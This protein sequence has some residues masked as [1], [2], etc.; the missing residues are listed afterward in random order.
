MTLSPDDVDTL[1]SA[2]AVARIRHAQFAAGH[3]RTVGGTRRMRRGGWAPAALRR[4]TSTFAGTSVSR[5]G[6]SCRHLAADA[7]VR[8]G[9]M[10]FLH[11]ATSRWV[12]ATRS[13]VG[14]STPGAARTSSSTRWSIATPPSKPE[15]FRVFGVGLYAGLALAAFGDAGTA[16]SQSG[17]LFRGRHRGRR[18]RPADVSAVCQHDPP[19]FRPGRWQRPRAFR[20]QREVGCAAKP[21]AI[22]EVGRVPIPHSRAGPGLVS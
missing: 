1:V 7:A 15:P 18:H 16:W 4:W 17:R 9:P 19:R 3:H 8:A 22:A 2:G 12:E 13:E 11:T 6:R 10:S 14:G 20:H 5:V 21:R